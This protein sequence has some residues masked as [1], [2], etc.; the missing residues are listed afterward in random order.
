MKK[1]F[2]FLAVLTGL[3]FG[4]DWIS[5]TIDSGGTT[6]KIFLDRNDDVHLLA[7]KVDTPWT[8][9]N[10]TFQAYDW[11]NKEYVDL[12]DYDGTEI[13]ITVDSTKPN[14]Y[15]MKPVWSYMFTDSVTIRSGTSATPVTQAD[16]RTLEIKR[17]KIR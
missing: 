3:T 2:F 12:I 9:A 4:Q 17:G 10:L 1:L 16:E 8:D 13:A 14:I 11:V 7:V 5:A 6:T 15:I